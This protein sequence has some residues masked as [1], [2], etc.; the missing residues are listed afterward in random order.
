MVEVV[1]EAGVEVTVV[2]PETALEVALGPLPPPPL[3][4]LASPARR[5]PFARPLWRPLQLLRPLQQTLQT[6]AALLL[7]PPP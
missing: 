5:P 1:E 2:G 7:P 4:A 6:Q 3:L